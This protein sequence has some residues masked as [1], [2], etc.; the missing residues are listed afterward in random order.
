MK[1]YSLSQKEMQLPENFKPLRQDLWVIY[2]Y[3]KNEQRVED[4][5]TFNFRRFKIS[6]NEFE[7]FFDFTYISQ[8]G[9]LPSVKIFKN[10]KS[11]KI[12]F[13]DPTGKITDEIFFKT[14]F[15]HLELNCDY[16]SS[17]LLKYQISY[18][19]EEFLSSKN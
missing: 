4:L 14:K 6:S 12:D 8:A 10:I 7:Y 3:N 5:E 18:Q 1:N 13:L 19:I 15:K 17:D 16:S 9:K 11:F 2:S